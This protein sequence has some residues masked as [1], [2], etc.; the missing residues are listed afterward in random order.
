MRYEKEVNTEKERGCKNGKQRGVGQWHTRAKAEV[1]Q[2]VG[3]N[4][5]TPTAS[6][7]HPT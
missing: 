2:N 7:P 6:F 5:P 1:G 3:V 4:Q